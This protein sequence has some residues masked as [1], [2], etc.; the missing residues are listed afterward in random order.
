MAAAKDRIAYLR[1][2]LGVMAAAALLIG[3]FLIANTFSIVVSQRTR[4]LAMLRAAGATAGQVHRMVLGEALAVGVV[5][6][7]LGTALGILAALGLRDLVGAFGI[8][9]PD[10][11][12]TVLPRSLL[13]GFAVGVLVTV[14]AAYGP[15]RRA[16]RVA[17]LAALRDSAR[18]DRHSHARTIAGQTLAIAG[19]AMPVGVVW[20]GVTP[21]WLGFGAVCTVL[22]LL[23]LGPSVTRRSMTALGRLL[24][25]REG[26]AAASTLL[27]VR[28]A[29]KFAARSPRRTAATVLA[30]ALSLGLIAFMA[31]LASSSRSG[32]A[33]SY[34]EVVT[35][36]YVV[37]SA[38]G[39]M[40]G[41]LAPGVER[42]LRE[43]PQVE[44]ASATRFGH[45]RDAG[46]ANALTSV[47]PATIGE[48]TDLH[49]VAGSLDALAD[50][51]RR[52]VVVAAGAA[53]KRHLEVGDRVR[54]EFSRVGRQDLPVVGLLEDGDA[55]ALSTDFVVSHRTYDQLYSERM[56]ASVFLVTKGDAGSARA[57]IEKALADHPTADLRDQAA[58]IAGRT[59]SIDQILGL[60]TV[61]LLFTVVMAA[62]GITN[63]MALSVL[64]RTR[65]LGLLRSVG[66]T[67]AQLRGMVRGESVLIAVLA[68][69]AGALVGTGYAAAVVHVLGADS[70]IP[71]T[72]PWARLAAISAV[73]VVA[74]LVAAVAPARRAARLDVLDAIRT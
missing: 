16:A 51:G 56:D 18:E 30:L 34:R 46:S 26:R 3:A 73:A 29:T 70:G 38:R 28:L 17:P 74:G 45:W 42:S 32:V 62:L 44:V 24:G 20:F 47:D 6:S 4:E 31:V 49:L 5:G 64:E 33:S 54:M 63:T 10:G 1:L 59:A 14:V 13:L 58:A 40:L 15:S 53:K 25:R 2:M 68:V 66:M 7:A 67:R 57:A 55:A 39:E 8:A 50:T 43:V 21:G 12:V 52:G 9:V 11:T 60:V 71:T 61:L 36:D 23:L 41:G 48:V 27:P 19:V 72:V 69:V 37:E 22:A 35:A 65:E